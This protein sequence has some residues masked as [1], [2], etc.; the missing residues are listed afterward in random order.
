[1]AGFE[2]VAT[3]APQASGWDA[4]ATPY[5]SP[6]FPDV[7]GVQKM[8]QDNLA[9]ANDNK[10]D[11]KPPPTP[12]EYVSTAAGFPVDKVINGSAQPS[13]INAA[14]RVQYT[15][16]IDNG[17]AIN[18]SDWLPTMLLHGIAPIASGLIQNAQHPLDTM[19]DI[20][21]T[22]GSEAAKG[23]VY[24]AT[25]TPGSLASDVMQSIVAPLVAT[26]TKL[27]GA[28]YEGMGGEFSL[29][30]AKFLTNPIPE[31]AQSPL[32]PVRSLLQPDYKPQ[33]F[34]GEATQQAANVVP[35]L[36]G[37]EVSAARKITGIAMAGLGG[38]LGEQGQ[39]TEKGKQIGRLIGSL[40]GFIYGASNPIGES[41]AAKLGKDP[42]AVTLQD[43]SQAVAEGSKD[44]HPPASDFKTAATATGVPEK[45]FK[46][47][48]N[49]GGVTPEKIITDAQQDPTI[50][51]DVAAG[52]VPEAYEH[53]VE[54]R[55][56]PTEQ[57]EK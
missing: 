45:G 41:V 57:A 54:D 32:A 49:D 51:S 8:A 50:L 21:K 28:A 24:M 46:T 55:Q 29:P 43:V 22:A 33:T 13:D 14:N 39:N 40:P 23:A 2:D 31:F 44:L 11:G 15:K 56:F 5:T 52:K 20:A 19:E 35:Y 1:M 17:S 26:A 38:A 16:A 47:V 36:A 30:W 4:V 6:N 10:V 27:A 42:A 9:A 12:L 3:P 18:S 48:Y 37:G 34:M 7:S 53:L 25:S